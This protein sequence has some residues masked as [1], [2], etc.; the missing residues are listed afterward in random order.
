MK[1]M[2]FSFQRRQVKGV[3]SLKIRVGYLDMQ[4]PQSAVPASYSHI[5]PSTYLKAQDMGIPKIYVAQVNKY[6]F[7]CI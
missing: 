2:I 3:P 4:A 1:W 7:S 6:P 5:F